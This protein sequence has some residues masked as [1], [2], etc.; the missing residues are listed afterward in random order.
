MVDAMTTTTGRVSVGLFVDEIG[1]AEQSLAG[2]PATPHAYD[3]IITFGFSHTMGGFNAGS[4][5]FAIYVAVADG[6]AVTFITTETGV[7]CFEI[8]LPPRS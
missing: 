7:Q 1:Y 4:H 2:A 8:L 3:G 6:S 5:D